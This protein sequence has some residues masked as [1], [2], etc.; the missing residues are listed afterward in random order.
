[1]EHF[2]LV[3]NIFRTHNII[4]YILFVCSAVIT[5]DL[6]GLRKILG[7]DLIGQP[8]IAIIGVIFLICVASFAFLIANSVFG[9]IILKIKNFF[10]VRSLKKELEKNIGDLSKREI[11]IIL[12]YFLQDTDTIWLPLEGAE[13]TSLV[14]KKLIFLSQVNGRGMTNGM[15]I[16]HYSTYPGVKDRFRQEYPEFFGTEEDVTDL[17]DFIRKNTPPYI[18]EMNEMNRTWNIW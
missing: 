3:L 12:L 11:V 18:H 1:M 13:I 8:Y 14:R 4:L 9:N 6:L 7:I 10:K 17:M 2:K 16:F 5:F 15:R